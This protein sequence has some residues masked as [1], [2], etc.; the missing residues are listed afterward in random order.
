MMALLINAE[1]ALLAL[2]LLADVRLGLV[3]GY[4][5]W[6]NRLSKVASKR[7][8]VMVRCNSV[9]CSVG[10]PNQ[11]QNSLLHLPRSLPTV[12]HVVI[13]QGDKRPSGIFTTWLLEHMNGF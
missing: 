11:G 10:R 2:G 7:L 13:R 3:V 5:A 4:Q 6:N 8:E 9:A 1:L 12:R